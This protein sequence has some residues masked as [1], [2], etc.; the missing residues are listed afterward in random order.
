[1]TTKENLRADFDKCYE[2]FEGIQDVTAKS[3]KDM[4]YAMY[5]SGVMYITAEAELI[6]C[7]PV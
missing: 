4:A 5:L 7:P 2:P 6:D 1:M 3:I